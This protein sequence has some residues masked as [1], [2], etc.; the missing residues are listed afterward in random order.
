MNKQI[1][2]RKATK[3]FLLFALS[4]ISMS[5]FS[6]QGQSSKEIK[7]LQL[8]TIVDSI[9]I[10]LY[11]IEGSKVD[12]YGVSQCEKYS[13]YQGGVDAKAATIYGMDLPR[14]FANLLM[15]SEKFVK[16][17]S[18]KLPK[19][20][21]SLQLST[22]KDKL[23]DLLPVVQC[24]SDYYGVQA[25][26]VQK[27]IEVYLLNLTDSNLFVDK[28]S[29]EPSDDLPMTLKMYENEILIENYTLEAFAGYLNRE[30]AT[31]GVILSDLV[32]DASANRRFTLSIPQETF[33]DIDKLMLFLNE[34]LG[35]EHVLEIVPQ[36][37]LILRDK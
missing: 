16:N 28:Y 11:S 29:S 19:Y 4:L 36:D 15:S 23:G 6:C 30:L 12:E 37:Y 8:D 34:K 32:D 1:L 3:L 31:S 21:V 25:S 14:T 20:F 27:E 10:S 33:N 17:E 2:I 13:S 35:L 24:I 22:E 26:L 5:F 7:T 9:K 18:S